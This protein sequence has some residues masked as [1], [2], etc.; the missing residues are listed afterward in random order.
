[1]TSSNKNL[2]DDLCK[3]LKPKKAL[4]QKKLYL[5][6]LIGMLALMVLPLL[7]MGLQNNMVETAKTPS[8]FIP[9]TLLAALAA[10]SL[11]FTLGLARPGF[12][13][14]KIFWF[15]T[16][17][18]PLVIIL[19]L[20]LVSMSKLNIIHD[21][22]EQF[23]LGH[24]CFSVTVLMTLAP[25]I[26]L[27]VISRSLFPFHP[28]KNAWMIS[29][30]SFLFASF[31]MQWHCANSHV[32]HLTLWHYA[33]IFLGSLLMALPLQFWLKPQNKS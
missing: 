32:C 30:T 2:I 17:A 26:L 23:S 10:I 11:W 28:F 13:P 1:M 19:G 20:N 25:T 3:D 15:F 8:F 31:T 24:A 4:P 29:L 27:T 18:S 9:T 22:T 7:I 14:K 21:Y 5:L 33:P 6:S 12:Q 16:I